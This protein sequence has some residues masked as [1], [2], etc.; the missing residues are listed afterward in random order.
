MTNPM[1]ILFAGS[2]DDVDAKTS[3]SVVITNTQS[4]EFHPIVISI[5]VVE[6]SGVTTPANISVGSNSPDFNNILAAATV[7]SV[8]STSLSIQNLFTAGIKIPSST[9]IKVKKTA[10][11]VAT[12]LKFR[13]ALFGSNGF[14]V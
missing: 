1:G 10:Q 7:G 9:D 14:P 12:T 13:V 8:G 5:E 2:P 6:A 4:D 11:A 3:G